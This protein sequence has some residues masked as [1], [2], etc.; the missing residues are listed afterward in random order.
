MPHTDAMQ[1]APPAGSSCP[2][3]ASCNVGSPVNPILG[4]KVLAGTEDQDFVLPGPLVL[5]WQR[6]Y[7]STNNDVGWFGRG[8][9]STLELRLDTVPDPTG[10]QVE[11][12]EYVDPFGRRTAFESLEQGGS[13]YS[14]TAKLE[15]TRGDDGRYR[16]TGPDGV[17]LR[18]AD[19]IGAVY[20]LAAIADRN[21]NAVELDYAHAADGLV[22]VVASGGQRLELI[23]DGGRLMAINEF[24][25]TDGAVSRLSLMRYGYTDRGDL[26]QVINRANETIRRFDYTNGRMMRRHVYAETFEASTNTPGRAP[27]RRSCGTGTTSDGVGRSSTI[28][29]TRRSPIRTVAR[30]C[31]ISMR[32][33]A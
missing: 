28:R 33:S 2:V 32:R 3:G 19:R 22:H 27:R 1:P 7:L 25:A 13:Q 24:R 20:R 31:T 26:A 17:T 8:W 18:F 30:S 6:Y 5:T 23:F 4:A 11:S 10:V 16:L 15:L 14:P 21:G 12:I 9:T 29:I